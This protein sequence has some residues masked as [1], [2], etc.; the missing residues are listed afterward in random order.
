[1]PSVKFARRLDMALCGLNRMAVS[2][3]ASQGRGGN[4]SLLE[5]TLQ[6]DC[7]DFVGAR[8][9]RKQNLLN[10]RDE[11]LAALEMTVRSKCGPDATGR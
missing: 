7:P 1:M 3:R 4:I 8:R 5:I 11:A 10:H 9:D 6:P 2:W